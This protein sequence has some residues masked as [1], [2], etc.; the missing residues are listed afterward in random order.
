[1]NLFITLFT[2]CLLLIIS[3][4]DYR[5]RAISWIPLILL[6]ITFI[7]KGIY[8]EGLTL[9][10]YSSGVS[11]LFVLIQFMM[12]TLYLLIKSRKL[13]NIFKK[14]IGIGD[15]LFLHTITLYLTPY[16]F[17]IFYI[18]GLSISLIAVYLYRAI[19][20]KMMKTIPLAGM[21]ATFLLILV[22]GQELF[23]FQQYISNRFNILLLPLLI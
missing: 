6:W 19:S 13:I 18:V 22:A 23:P 17:I 1:M 8:N 11:N 9:L 5:F 21:L 3:Y 12:V 10:L 15:V 4:Q 14:H 7:I 2:F 20:G 16:L